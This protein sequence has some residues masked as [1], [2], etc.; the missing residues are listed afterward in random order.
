[1][2]EDA[3]PHRYPHPSFTIESEEDQSSIYD[4]FLVDYLDLQVSCV[5]PLQSAVQAHPFSRFR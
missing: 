4:T 2:W 5:I 1:M 3:A